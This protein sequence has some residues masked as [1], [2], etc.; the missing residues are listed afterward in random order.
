ML[1]RKYQALALAGMKNSHSIVHLGLSGATS[2]AYPGNSSNFC[3]SCLHPEP[4]TQRTFKAHSKYDY[5][6]GVTSVPVC[7]LRRG[8]RHVE[9]T[10]VP[11]IEGRLKLLQGSKAFNCRCRKNFCSH[12]PQWRATRDA[13]TLRDQERTAAEQQKTSTAVLRIAKESGVAKISTPVP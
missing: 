8:R 1:I 7:V 6:I 9:H 5:V 12:S 3:S 10:D 2:R 4:F 13:K 11:E